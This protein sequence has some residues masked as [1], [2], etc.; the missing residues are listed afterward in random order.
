MG[1][2]IARSGVGRAAAS[3]AWPHTT[4]RSGWSGSR[5]WPGHL[6]SFSPQ[7]CARDG[8]GLLVGVMYDAGLGLMMSE[9]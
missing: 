9:P 1:G 4:A 5:P 6:P 8:H 2:L 3:Q 7:T